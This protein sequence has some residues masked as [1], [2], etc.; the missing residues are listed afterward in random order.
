VEQNRNSP[1]IFARS[2]AAMA[3]QCAALALA[4]VAQANAANRAPMISG[5]PDASVLAGERYVFR[6][7]AHDAD[8]D[9]LHFSV[10]N[11]PRWASFD[12]STGRLSGT[13]GNG[14]GGTFS[15]IRIRVS[16][17]RKSD[18]LEPFSIVV[19]ASNRAPRI[20]GRP[21]ASV[22]AGRTYTFRPSASDPDGNRLFFR[23]VNRPAWATFSASTGRLTGVPSA[24]AAGEYVGVRISVSDGRSTT[25]LAPF[26]VVVSKPNHNPVISG[27]PAVEALAG[28]PY[29]FQANASDADGDDLRFTIANLPSWA[30]F[31][32]ATGR[33]AGTPGAATVGTYENLTIRVTDGVATVA[34]PA[35]SITV[36]QAVSGSA[37]L[38]W[39]P[40]TDRVDG[41]PLTN[42]AG[43]R[44]RYGTRPDSL[45]EVVEIPNGGITSAVIENLPPAT[46]YFVASA[47]DTDGLESTN[48]VPVSKTIT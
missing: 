47:Y 9:R 21:P 34:L 28:Q 1:R 17:G 46:W 20:S 5:S 26:S 27:T 45:T 48:T 24:S 30:T 42:L 4:S 12:P 19:R 10:L 7:R 32:A 33:L 6:P 31:D 16:D 14:A 44:I 18:A 2:I 23:I 35:F 29:L 38:S 41:S 43:Y 39:L 22:V 13:P 15:N 40:P 11:K 8:G 36:Q 3:L 37:T 25:W